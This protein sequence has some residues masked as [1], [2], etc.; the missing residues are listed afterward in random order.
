MVANKYK[1]TFFTKVAIEV[2]QGNAVTQAVVGGLTIYP[3]AANIPECIH[4][5]KK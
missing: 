2:V 4:V 3:P 1:H 5:R